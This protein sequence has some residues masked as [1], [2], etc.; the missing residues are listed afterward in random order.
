MVEALGEVNIQSS[1]HTGI[2]AADFVG[3]SQ[4]K[5]RDFYRIGKVLG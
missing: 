4:G 1:Q 2:R 5:L 3:R